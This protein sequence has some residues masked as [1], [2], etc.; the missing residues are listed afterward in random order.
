MMCRNL[1]VRNERFGGISWTLWHART[2][3][4]P[5]RSEPEIRLGLYSGGS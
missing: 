5:S 4:P 1:V 2:H 3:F